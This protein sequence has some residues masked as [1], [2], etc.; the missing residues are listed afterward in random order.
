MKESLGL[1]K[2]V[3]PTETLKTPSC[4]QDNNKEL[5]GETRM[6]RICEGETR[7]VGWRFLISLAETPSG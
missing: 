6:N 3:D 4:C 1:M 2:R 5:L 7:E